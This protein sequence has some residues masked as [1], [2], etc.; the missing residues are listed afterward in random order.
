MLA[1]LLSGGAVPGDIRTTEDQTE[2][3]QGGANTRLES[4]HDVLVGSQTSHGCGVHAPK[5]REGDRIDHRRQQVSDVR[6]LDDKCSF[7]W[8]TE[9][10]RGSFPCDLHLH[11][12]QAVD[13]VTVLRQSFDVHQHSMWA[14]EGEHERANRVF[15]PQQHAEHA[16]L[17]ADLHV[18]LGDGAHHVAVFEDHANFVRFQGH[19]CLLW[20]I[21]VL[22][23]LGDDGGVGSPVELHA[24]TSWSSRRCT[25]CVQG[26]CSGFESIADASRP[27]G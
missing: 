18:L 4:E 12:D 2:L 13:L 26:T 8:K 7:G 16:E 5:V 17:W 10:T 23:V 27:R 14:G 21:G 9:Q 11:G 25:C 3:V 20:H 24:F 1:L 15:F 19:L 22:Q 6:R